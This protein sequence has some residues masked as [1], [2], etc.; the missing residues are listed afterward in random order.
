MAQVPTPIPIKL[1]INRNIADAVALMSGLT[2]C[3]KAE[4]TGPSQASPRAVGT[5]KTVLPADRAAVEGHT[6]DQQ[7]RPVKKRGVQQAQA[8]TADQE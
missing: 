4:I 6:A 8:I 3:C 2:R 1:I 7:Y 5:S